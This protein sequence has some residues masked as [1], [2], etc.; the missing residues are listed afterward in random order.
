MRKLINYCDFYNF[1]QHNLQKSIWKFH[2]I[3]ANIDLL[4]HALYSVG[5]KLFFVLNA[6]T[7]SFSNLNLIL[8]TEQLHAKW[9][10]GMNAIIITIF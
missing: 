6:A 3:A 2:H 1:A 7:I 9:E 8:K 5:S 4:N 10:F